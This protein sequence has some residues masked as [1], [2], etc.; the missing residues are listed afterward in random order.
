MHS[1]SSTIIRASRFSHKGVDYV[2]TVFIN[3]IEPWNYHV[4]VLSGGKPVAITYKDGYKASLS[5]LVS[6]TTRFDMKRSLDID[7]LSHLAQTAEADI[8]NLI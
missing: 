1:P 7:A 2:T 3:P 4:E 6:L 5:Y 8:R